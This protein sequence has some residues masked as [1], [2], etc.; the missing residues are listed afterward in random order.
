MP[1]AAPSWSQA[2]CAQRQ[3]QV[4]VDDQ[5]ALIRH[6]VETSQRHHC[7][8]TLIHERL[9]L[10]QNDPPSMEIAQ[11]NVSPLLALVKAHTKG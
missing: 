2:Q 4:I 11:G 7:L 5:Q 8:S 3:V 9:R 10:G 1:T 6:P